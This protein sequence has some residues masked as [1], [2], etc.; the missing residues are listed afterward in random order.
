MVS[1]REV[2]TAL[3]GVLMSSPGCLLGP[4]FVGDL[5]TA[6][7]EGGGSVGGP[8]DSGGRATSTTGV[9]GSGGSVGSDG[10]GEA[11]DDSG[12]MGVELHGTRIQLA[13]DPSGDLLALG[14]GV[15][16]AVTLQR[17]TPEGAFVRSESIA[18][19]PP[20]TL[21]EFVIKGD[22]VAVL[23]DDGDN[24]YTVQ[25]RS[26]DVLTAMWTTSEPG[27]DALDAAWMAADDLAIA[28]G[29]ILV[30]GEYLLDDIPP[31]LPHYLLFRRYSSAGAR[32]TDQTWDMENQSSWY[33]FM[34]GPALHP[35]V[36]RMRARRGL[37]LDANLDVARARMPRVP[38]VLADAP[39]RIGDHWVAVAM[40]DDR[41]A[42][43]IT[44]VDATFHA[45]VTQ[46]EDADEFTMAL[47]VVAT[48]D[49][50]GVFTW[51]YKPEE[52]SLLFRRYD[53]AGTLLAIEEIQHGILDVYCSGGVFEVVHGVDG[54]LFAVVPGCDADHEG[55]ATLQRLAP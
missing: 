24:G 1:M 29:Q 35:W 22:M 20:G 45:A 19:V 39:V 8:D 38:Y 13:V 43:A 36:W 27:I 14:H 25:R 5:E 53:A 33:R 18:D 21:T 49:G 42:L 41:P 6:S 16:D 32:L 55:R 37:E 51:R 40:A 23:F 46:Y 26:A 15:G 11:C 3:V 50:F 54:S 44:V 17:F 2:H 9:D 12:G 48:R 28:D 47:R 34:E 4:T 31:I 52:E 30:V 7:G 10:C